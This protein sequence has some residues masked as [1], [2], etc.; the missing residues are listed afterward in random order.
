MAD[1]PRP[2]SSAMRRLIDVAPADW[3]ALPVGCTNLTLE[4]LEARGLVETRYQC[5]DQ[6]HRSRWEWRVK[7]HLNIGSV[8]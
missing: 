2:L 6:P 4:A 8:T 1:K 3:K 5:P 7:P